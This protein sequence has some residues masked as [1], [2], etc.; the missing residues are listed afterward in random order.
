MYRLSDEL[1]I[2]AYHKANE[3]SLSPDFIHLMEAEIHRR[4]LSHKLKVS[5]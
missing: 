1:L 3:L 4:S 2:E 5:S